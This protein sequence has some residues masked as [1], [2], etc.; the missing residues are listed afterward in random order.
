ME[1]SIHDD[2]RECE[3]P[4]V[5][6]VR[7][8]QLPPLAPFNVDLRAENIFQRIFAVCFLFFSSTMN[9]FANVQWKKNTLWFILTS[10]WNTSAEIDN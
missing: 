7:L 1:Y 10:R 2:I 9:L 3:L 8:P 4:I 6:Y 5:V